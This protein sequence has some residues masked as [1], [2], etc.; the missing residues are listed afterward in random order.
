MPGFQDGTDS[1]APNGDY[2]RRQFPALGAR[3]SHED[4]RTAEYRTTHTCSIFSASMG[5]HM[6]LR[7]S[8]RG[9][10]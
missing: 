10:Q 2:A 5:W 1:T 3:C 7:S 9:A 6:L 4:L 8:L